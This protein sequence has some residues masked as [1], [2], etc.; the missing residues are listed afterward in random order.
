MH[1]KVTTDEVIYNNFRQLLEFRIGNVRNYADVCSAVK[2]SNIVINAAA[3][4]QVPLCE[5]F[6]EQAIRTNC[7][8]P[9]N[10][11]R[12][13]RENDYCLITPNLVSL[14]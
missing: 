9:E 3:L 13:I 4:K 2:D 1:S 7:M 6:P 10:I 8:G 14:H 12:A 5:Y 11:V